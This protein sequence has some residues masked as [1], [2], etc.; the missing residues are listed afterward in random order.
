MKVRASELRTKDVI[1][2]ADGRKLGNLYDL[3]IDVESGRIRSLLLPAGSRPGWFRTRERDVEV[4]WQDI[5]K[6]GIDVILVDL[7]GSVSPRLS[8]DPP[9]HGL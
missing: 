9:S 1:N 6:V 4:P 8:A 3:D 5:V 2:V 7:P